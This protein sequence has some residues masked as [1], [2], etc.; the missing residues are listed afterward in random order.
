MMQQSLRNRARFIFAKV[1]LKRNIGGLIEGIDRVQELGV[2]G[3]VRHS[4][5]W[6]PIWE[7]PKIRGA[8]FWSP[9]NKGL[10]I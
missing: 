3:W 9:Y 2:C 1:F 4:V 6:T 8:L 10:T 7:F 5:A